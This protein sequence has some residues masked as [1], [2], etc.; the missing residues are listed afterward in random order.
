MVVGLLRSC[1]CS[2]SSLVTLWQH[3][4]C[5]IPSSLRHQRCPGKQAQNLKGC[6]RIYWAL[7]SMS[8][9]RPYCIIVIW[10]LCHKIFIGMCF[11]TSL[12]SGQATPMRLPGVILEGNDHHHNMAKQ[13]LWRVRTTLNLQPCNTHVQA[14]S[15]PI[16]ATQTSACNLSNS[17]MD[18]H[19]S[20]TQLSLPSLDLP[21]LKAPRLLWALSRGA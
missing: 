8:Q 6:A 1:F 13:R 15:N 14:R 10:M 17:P 12:L 11:I 19:V 3:T 2:T 21:P 16:N 7:Q 4:N 5:T 18:P 20:P 9:R